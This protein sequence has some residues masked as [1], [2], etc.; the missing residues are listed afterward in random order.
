[1][2]ERGVFAVD[3][4]VFDHPIF[5]PEPFTEREAWVWL[6]GAAAWKSTKVRIGRKV[7]K[8]ERGQAVFSVRFLAKK[9]KWSPSRVNRFLVRL[10]IET[11]VSTLVNHEATHITICNYDN[12]QFGR[13]TRETPSETVGETPARHSRDKEEELKEVKKEEI[14]DSTSLRSVARDKRGTRLPEDWKPTVEDTS[15]AVSLGLSDSRIALEAAKFRDYWHAR[16]GP[17][18]VKLNWSATWRNWI[19]NADD[20]HGAGRNSKAGNGKSSGSD[21]FAGLAGVAADIA[22][23]GDLAGSAA[24]EVPLGRVNIDG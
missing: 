8:L 14:K 20:K 4:G 1:M 6:I 5:A 10:K 11:M 7:F 13:D 9:W 19:R 17:G 23:D 12:F 15:F 18:G 22:G 21:F 2:S 24:E 3:R 16:A